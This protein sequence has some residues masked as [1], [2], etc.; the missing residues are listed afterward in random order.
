M[1]KGLHGSKLI[2]GSREE[3]TDWRKKNGGQIEHVVEKNKR[4]YI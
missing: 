1:E 3:M 4:V 2:W